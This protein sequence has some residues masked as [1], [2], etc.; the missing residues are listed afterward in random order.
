[1]N[2]GKW[3]AVGML[4]FVVGM[5]YKESCKRMNLTKVKRQMMRAMGL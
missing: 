3:M 5:N 1:M 2:L 4:G